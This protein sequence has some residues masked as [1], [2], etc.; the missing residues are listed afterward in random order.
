MKIVLLFP[1]IKQAARCTCPSDGINRMMMILEQTPR[2]V[3]TKGL[4]AISNVICT[5]VSLGQSKTE[6]VQTLITFNVHI[7]A[8]AVGSNA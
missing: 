3:D 6:L 1:S 4:N 7:L 2:S 5:S 8:M